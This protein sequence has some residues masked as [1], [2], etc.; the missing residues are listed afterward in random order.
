MIEQKEFSFTLS[1]AHKISER[2]IRLINE[3][4]SELSSL[5]SPI[6]I[7]SDADLVKID[8]RLE[9]IKEAR[10]KLAQS[11]EV[12]RQ[13]RISIAE[14]NSKIG[15]N[16]LL[17]RKRDI[18]REKDQ[19]FQLK[20]SAHHSSRDAHDKGNIDTILVRLCTTNSMS[21][22]KARVADEDFISELDENIR[23]L[24]HESDA[25]SDK[26]ADLNASNKVS[27]SFK[28]DLAILL[29]L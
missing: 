25:L 21:G 29:G 22:V 15:L 12:S 17:T 1:R 10:Q 26:I 3:Q 18:D 23:S 19:M 4:S 6:Q 16:S 20:S 5:V 24:T 2:L 8:A 9:K 13:L 7:H 28:D 14:V 27:V 11:H